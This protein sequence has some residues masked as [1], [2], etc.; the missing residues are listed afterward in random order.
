[1]RVIVCIRK[2]ADRAAFLAAAGT[3]GILLEPVRGL[4]RHFIW[5]G[6]SP[7]DFPL[8]DH[9]SVAFV[10]DGDAPASGAAL[11]PITI[12]LAMNGGSWALARHIR[13]DA[14]WLVGP[15]MRHPI[16]TYFRSVRDGAG[17]DIYFGDTGI[18]YSHEE[19]GGRATF[20]GG[21]YGSGGVDDNGHGTGVASA[22]A[23]A[24]AGIARG[25]DL[26][27]VKLLDSSNAASVANI[28]IGIGLVLDDYASRSAFGRP[29]VLN[30]SIWASGTALS[31]VEAVE[32]CIDAGLVVVGIAGNDLAEAVPVPGSVDDVI[33]AGGL[34]ANDTPY[35]VGNYG[36]NFGARVDILAAAERVWCAGFSADDAFVRL[37]GTSMAAPLVSGVVACMLQGKGR[38]SSRAQVQ[39]VR[40]ALLANATTG[41][42]VPQ[43]Q[44]GIGELP[45]RI[46]WMDPDIA[47]EA[48][49]GL[50]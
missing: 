6:P 28:A 11:Q 20:V 38:L 49:E 42:F 25:A 3:A 4:D 37:S 22:A 18:R 16:Q 33:C 39:A 8:A 43:P 27:I 21:V 19:F 44:F 9:P 12:D 23:G 47:T 1:M 45:D 50:S 14:P 26:R 17:V 5:D 48:I 35:Y 2:G 13:R 46:L 24:T 32:D 40:A 41:R 15:R 31:I 30:L 10:E 29:A 7:S 34:K 36:T